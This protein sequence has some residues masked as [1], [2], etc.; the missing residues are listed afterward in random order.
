MDCVL[1]ALAEDVGAT[2]TTFDG[3]LLEHGGV[4][5]EELID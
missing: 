1:L 5:P 3:E 2:L 4:P